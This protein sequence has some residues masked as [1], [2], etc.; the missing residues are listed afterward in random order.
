MKVI[1]YAEMIQN[2]FKFTWNTV[3]YQ[4]CI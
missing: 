1:V 3:W 2:T 4:G